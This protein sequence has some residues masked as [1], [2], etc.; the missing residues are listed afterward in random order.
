M[1]SII[2]LKGSIKYHIEIPL[3]VSQNGLKNTVILSAVRM[4]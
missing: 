4:E 2:I 3:P 1:F